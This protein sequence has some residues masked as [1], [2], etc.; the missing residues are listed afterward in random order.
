MNHIKMISAS[1]GSLLC[2]SSLAFAVNNSPSETVQLTVN[3]PGMSSVHTSAYI[4]DGIANTLGGDKIKSKNWKNDQAILEIPAG[5]YDLKLTK[6]DA[7]HIIDNVDCSSGSCNVDNLVAEMTVNFPGMS[8]VHT[9]ARIPDG[10][11]GSAE[12]G[13]ITK[14]NWKTDQAILKVFTQVYD[15][16]VR[17]DQSTHIIDNVDCTSG[18]CKVDNLVA[19]MVVNFPGMS[20]VHTDARIP[21]GVDGSAEGGKVTAS[22]WKKD[23]AILKVFPQI[24]DVRVRK[25]QSTHIID[26]LDCT[27]GSCKV[28]NLVAEMVVNFPG[29]SSVHTDARIPDGVDGSA[30]GGKVTASNWKKDQVI[31]KVFPQVYD[32]RLRKDQS[33]HIVDNVDCRSGTCSVDNLVAYMTINF[34][35]MSSVHSDARVPDGV[36]GTADGGKVSAENWKKETATLT[37]F[38]KVYDVRI[39]KDK[40]TLIV[41]NVD[42]STGSCTVDDITAIMT[43]HFPGLTSMHS[44]VHLPD[45]QDNVASGEKVGKANWKNNQAEIV[46]LRQMYDV[47]VEKQGESSA[48]IYDNVD[49]SSA[50]CEILFEGNSQI[51]LID[52]DANTPIANQSLW[53]YEK[54]ADGSLSL[55]QKGITYTQ[56]N[57]NFSLP[58]LGAGRVYVAKISNPYGN[59]KKYYSPFITATGP[60]QFIVTRDGENTLDLIP[61][62][63]TITSPQ[64]NGNVSAKGFQISGTAEDNREVS[65]VSISIVQTSNTI[66]LN[67]QY[68]TVSKQWT[69]TVETALLEENTLTEI[70][71]LAND[72]AG[73]QS[74]SQITVNP[75]EDNSGPV[76][77]ISSQGP[78]F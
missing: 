54:F 77:I 37:L 30:E 20:S 35:G 25:D 73:N 24:Y 42:C 45:A 63:I 12:G 72:S 44:S 51:V 22:N 49:C 19:E 31:L 71:V 47:S 32:V 5:I 33:T 6:G 66:N 68:D 21:D 10:V 61:P 18:S 26:N 2:F 64:N 14:N 39:R 69:A 17:K 78:G 75:I 74:I 53:I 3:F 46:V 9:D 55:Y 50:N 4:S 41:D 65:N 52:G 7:I 29:M 57:A 13:Q 8:N 43:V 59:K 36:D 56:G 48:T 70:T 38:P 62:E 76:I 28:D 60:F 23:Q 27:S 40:S 58:G 16:R 15:V 1:I 11:D 34:P 67:A